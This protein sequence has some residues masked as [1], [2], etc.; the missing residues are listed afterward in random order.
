MR[1]TKEEFAWHIHKMQYQHNHVL[2]EEGI[3]IY[4]SRKP[5]TEEIKNKL[6]RLLS[7]FPDHRLVQLGSKEDF[8]HCFPLQYIHDIGVKYIA[9]QPPRKP[10]SPQ[11]SMAEYN[12]RYMTI[13]TGFRIIISSMKFFFY[14]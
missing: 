6:G 12:A 4:E 2:W 9:S 10:L 5:V 13:C 14:Y 11:M 8:G 1:D 7:C 3:H